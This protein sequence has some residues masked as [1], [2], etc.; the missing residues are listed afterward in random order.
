MLGK[1][2]G[3]WGGGRGAV[4]IGDGFIYSSPIFF[5]KWGRW[6]GVVVWW[7]GRRGSF[8]PSSKTMSGHLPLG[9]LCE[10]TRSVLCHGIAY[11]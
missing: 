4:N 8:F 5:E 2:E 9:G 6:E 11:V 7:G 3:E 1:W 10:G